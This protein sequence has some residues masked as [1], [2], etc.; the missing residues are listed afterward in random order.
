MLEIRYNKTTKKV[1]GW[2][3]DEAQF[4]LLKDRAGEKKVIIDV[5]IPPKNCTAYLYDP[6]GKI[7]IDNPDFVG[8][9]PPRNLAAEI[10]DLKARLT[11]LEP[12]E[13]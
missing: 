10:D 12:K 3:G 6:I 4:G 13:L 9:K 1:S 8:P 11:A 7:L 2:C 5:P